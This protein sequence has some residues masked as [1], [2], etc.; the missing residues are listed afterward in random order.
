MVVSLNL[1]S[2]FR[3]LIYRSMSC[4]S[5]ALSDRLCSTPVSD[6]LDRSTHILVV[7][8]SFV[9]FFCGRAGR[10]RGNQGDVSDGHASG[11]R[12]TL[13]VAVEGGEE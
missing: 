13:L 5:V 9:F 4:F 2:C 8:Q 12:R 1:F 6:F 3:A 7:L 11:Q 10:G